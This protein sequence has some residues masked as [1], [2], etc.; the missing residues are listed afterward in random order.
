MRSELGYKKG[1]KKMRIEAIAVGV[2]RE[3]GATGKN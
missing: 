3:K 2:Q 1:K